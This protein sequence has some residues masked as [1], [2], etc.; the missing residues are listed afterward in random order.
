[1][2]KFDEVKFEIEKEGW[3]VYE[4]IDGN[5]RVTLRMRAIL[6]K[7]LRPKIIK[8]KE[9]PL[10]GIPQGMQ[11]PPKVPKDEFQLSFQNI[12]VV[13]ECPAVLMGTPT[14]PVPPSELNKIAKEEIEFHP[15]D[16]DWNIYKTEDGVKLKIKLVV[17]SVR[18]AKG[19]FDQL[20]YP[21]YVV[22]STNAIVPTPPKVKK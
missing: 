16:E 14:P 20:G 9:P 10:I 3:N 4:L 7:I 18:K 8:I 21:L 17:S 1:M 22:Q 13:S 12:V 2:K 19:K 11:P 5:H 6:T 15:F